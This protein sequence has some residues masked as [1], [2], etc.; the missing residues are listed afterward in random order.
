MCEMILKS[1]TL[2][3]RKLT[4]GGRDVQ[5]N[6]CLHCRVI[7]C[8]MMFAI[9][10]MLQ[11]A[12]PTQRRMVGPR[13]GQAGK[14]LPEGGSSAERGAGRMMSGDGGG[15]VQV[16]G[17]ACAKAQ[18]RSFEQHFPQN[19]FFF[20]NEIPHNTIRAHIKCGLLCLE[21]QKL[22][23]VRYNHLLT[24]TRVKRFN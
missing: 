22:P 14:L 24:Q 11:G 13:A 17:T 15:I 3:L 9:C 12:V 4:A 18:N 20:L 19:T 8:I 21:C 5:A 6:R 7:M 10:G 16:K 1:T 2:K 23:F